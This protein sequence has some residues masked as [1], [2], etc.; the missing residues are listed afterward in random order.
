MMHACI[1]TYSVL[2][3]KF[4]WVQEAE[5]KAQLLKERIAGGWHCIILD[6]SSIMKSSLHYIIS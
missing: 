2:F 3:S 4:A 6:H 5:Q 1:H